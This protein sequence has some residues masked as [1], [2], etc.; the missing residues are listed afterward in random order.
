MTTTRRRAPRTT[1]ETV[2]E[3]VEEVASPYKA[4]R[5]FKLNGRPFGIG[6]FVPQE[7]WDSL[8]RPESL[9]RAGLVVEG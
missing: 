4:R 7:A 5:P 1:K 2:D 3:V 6:E 9:I 8:P